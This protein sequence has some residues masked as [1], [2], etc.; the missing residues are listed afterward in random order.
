MEE[1]DRDQT[2]ALLA[3]STTVH[4]ASQQVV[5]LPALGGSCT[6]IQGLN[7]GDKALNTCS[8]MCVG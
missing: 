8:L 7:H 1:G 6:V 2:W 5:E 4:L 3:F